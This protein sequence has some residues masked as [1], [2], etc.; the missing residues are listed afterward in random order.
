[1]PYRVMEVDGEEQAVTIHRLNG[2]APETFPPLSPHHLTDG[3]WWIAYLNAEA[4]AFAGMVEMIPFQN[5]AYLKRAYVLPDHRGHG[6]QSRFMTLR[7]AK[8]KSLG[9][10]HLVSECG[11]DN[12]ASAA[13]FSRAGF[14]RCDPEQVWGAP[15]SMYWIKLI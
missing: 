3:F 2:L 1:M 15:N 7:E 6:L 5:V 10:T 8:A 12:H 13:N 4:V 9:W 11:A 14:T